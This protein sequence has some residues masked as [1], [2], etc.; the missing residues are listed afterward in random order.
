MLNHSLQLKLL[1]LRMLNHSLQLKLLGLRMLN[2]SL[3]LKLLGLRM[4]PHSLQLKLL[5]FT[6][7]IASLCKFKFVWHD[8]LY[9]GIDVTGYDQ[10]FLLI[11]SVNYS[12]HQFVTFRFTR[13]LF[14]LPLLHFML[15]RLCTVSAACPVSFPLSLVT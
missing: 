3:Q 5:G 10:V 4:L 14:L 15:S 7:F 6:Y 9:F 1:G 13:L 12:L 2:H 11:C 8:Y